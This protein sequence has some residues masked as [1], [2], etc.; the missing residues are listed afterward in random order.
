M[1]KKYLVI[2]LAILL[3]CMVSVTAALSQRSP[4]VCN[5]QWTSCSNGNANDANRATFTATSTLNGTGAW[6]TYGF[7]LQNGAIITDVLV[8]ADF[9][10]SNSRGF[11]DVK[12]SGN[13]GT[14]YGPSHVVGG[15]TAEQTFNISVTSDLSWTPS[16]LNNGNF[17]VNATC[18]KSPTGGPNPTCNLDWIP[19]TVT[20]TPFDYSLAVSPANVNVTQGNNATT[21][22]T[23]TLVSGNS[24]T[25]A[26]SYSG[27]PTN[28]VCS[29]VSSSGTPTFSSDFIVQTS[30]GNGSNSSSTP[31]GTYVIALNSFGDGVAR[32]QN[33]TLNV[34]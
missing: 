33:Y 26:L 20:Y 34:Q 8:Q 6:K 13:N 21:T 9:F 18:F 30:L 25:V 28:A 5:G 32:S 2:F 19:V 14:T 27:C 1:N 3:V 10:A 7:A 15:N 12:V 17:R 24:Q 29:F 16:M 22:V 11:L 4:T 31:L 23:A